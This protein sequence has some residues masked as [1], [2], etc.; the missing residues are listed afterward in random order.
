MPEAAPIFNAV[1]R[2][3]LTNTVATALWP[4]LLIRS[5]RPMNGRPTGPWPQLRV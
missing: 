1:Y 4:V 2:P 3:R 5:E